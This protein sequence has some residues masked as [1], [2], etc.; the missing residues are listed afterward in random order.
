MK[1]PDHKTYLFCGVGGSGMSAL[2]LICAQQRHNVFGSDR[3]YDQGQSPD[4]FAEL[5]KQGIKLVPQD[6]SGVTEGLDALVV[7]SAIEETIPDVAAAKAKNVP[8]IKRA[9][10]LAQMFNAVQIGISVAGTSGK[11]TV[12]GMIAHILIEL[13][14]DPTVMN[15]AVI[16]NLGANMRVGTGPFV[17][18]T[19]ESDGSIVLY[20]P[21]ISV[22]NNVA[23]DHKTMEEL[24]A[25]F[26]DF[27]NRASQAVVLNGDDSRLMALAERAS[28]AVFNYSLSDAKD[29]TPNP[30][31]TG[32]S[33]K[34]HDVHLQLA[35]MHNISNA[36]AALRVCEVL[37]IPLARA[38]DALS[39]FR[40]IKR[41]MDVVGTKNN[42]TVIDDFGHNPDKIAATLKTLKAFEGRLI[43]MF[44]MHG[45]GPLKLIGKGI[46][47]A[48]AHYLGS[49]DL[50]LLPEAYYAGGTVDRSVSM[51]DVTIW[52]AEQGAQ[53]TW[54]ETR[55]E[56]EPY[57][58]K[59]ARPG[60]R[61]IIMGARDDTLS[62]F[63]VR[64]LEK[65]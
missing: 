43:V 32:F 34:G 51:K 57:I 53:A 26:G 22:V 27:I 11:S 4:K 1:Q 58:L 7:S 63:A 48:F 25:L 37:D 21:A 8:I 30:Y 23:L 29:I 61:I 20:N 36:L 28:V 3:S 12:T 55:A 2:A 47:E 31:G 33:Y 19:D 42:I 18:E 59:H 65:L 40:G 49:D 13:G 64:I 54:F 38:A 24:E 50:L 6:G 10:L 17:T 56:I 52:A 62:D 35:G 60:D 9:E 44:Q 41:R 15:G 39:T 14:H 16:K 45:Y 5:E 46:A